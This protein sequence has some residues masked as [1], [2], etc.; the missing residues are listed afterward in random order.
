M[1]KYLQ[2]II[3][4]CVDRKREKKLRLSGC[5]NASGGGLKCHLVSSSWQNIMGLFSVTS[6]NL[7]ALQYHTV[8]VEQNNFSIGKSISSTEADVLDLS[9]G[10]L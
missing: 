3:L 4:G 1:P 5:S 9:G 10:I 2:L 8:G 6:E 7:F